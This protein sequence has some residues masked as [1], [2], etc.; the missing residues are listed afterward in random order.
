MFKKI[1]GPSPLLYG[2]KK[3]HSHLFFR[4]GSKNNDYLSDDTF[5]EIM[6]ETLDPN[7]KK[8]RRL[9]NKEVRELFSNTAK[10]SKEQRLLGSVIEE[11]KVSKIISYKSFQNIQDMYEF[12][13]KYKTYL[14]MKRFVPLTLHLN[15]SQP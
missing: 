11:A 10:L 7:P 6:T 9:N 4:E 8:P 15:K 13:R 12:R 5:F 2:V 14:R 3:V 1:L